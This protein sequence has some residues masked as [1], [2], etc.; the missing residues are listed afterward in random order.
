MP[1]KKKSSAG[2]QPKKKPSAGAI[3]E[4]KGLAAR[5]RQWTNTCDI[6]EGK[7][8][9]DRIR[10]LYEFR[11]NA[12]QKILG[13]RWKHATAGYLYHEHSS[14]NKGWQ[15]GWY[16]PDADEVSDHEFNIAV[17]HTTETAT[18]KAFDQ[19]CFKEIFTAFQ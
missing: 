9:A 18:E 10:N 7:W 14:D 19:S 6:Q 11:V 17:I 12:L 15:Y 8:E 2:A 3:A 1:K 16:C 5:R 4:D 13:P